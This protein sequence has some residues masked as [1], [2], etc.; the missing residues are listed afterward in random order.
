MRRGVEAD[1]VTL[2]CCSRVTA[3][4]WSLPGLPEKILPENVALS[5]PDKSRGGCHEIHDQGELKHGCKEILLCQRDPW[6]DSGST[7]LLLLIGRLSS[8]RNFAKRYQILLQG[9]CLRCFAVRL[10]LWPKAQ[11]Q[12]I[13]IVV[14]QTFTFTWF[15]MLISQI[16]WFS[17]LLF[18][19]KNNVF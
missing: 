2:L 9:C 12:E 5:A 14:Y 15:L 19:R 13:F 1:F 3:L 11:E 17:V 16:E 10:G 8:V 18:T 7:D 4:I 6:E